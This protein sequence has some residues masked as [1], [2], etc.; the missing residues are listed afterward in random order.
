MLS[1]ETGGVKGPALGTFQLNKRRQTPFGLWK[2][3]HSCRRA[4]QGLF[5]LSL[6]FMVITDHKARLLDSLGAARLGSL[7]VVRD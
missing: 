1:A 6:R 2:T 3:L 7:S 5:L 4:P